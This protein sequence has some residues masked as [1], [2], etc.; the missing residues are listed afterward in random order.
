MK[1]AARQAAQAHPQ[2]PAPQPQGQL[3]LLPLGQDQQ[4]PE[5]Q[6]LGHHDPGPVE[7]DQAPQGQSSGGWRHHLLRPVDSRAG[8]A[9]RTLD[10]SDDSL[11]ICASWDM[12]KSHQSIISR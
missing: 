3:Q 11:F 12:G 2:E 8:G 7:Q 4:L 10:F 1:A 5:D 6:D 9:V